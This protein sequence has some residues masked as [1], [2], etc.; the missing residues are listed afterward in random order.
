M[1]HADN[2]VLHGNGNG[3]GEVGGVILLRTGQVTFPI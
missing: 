1:V 3:G 2:A